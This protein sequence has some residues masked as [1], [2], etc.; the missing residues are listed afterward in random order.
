MVD[1]MCLN[2]YPCPSI[3]SF[4]QGLSCVSNTVAQEHCIK[5]GGHLAHRVLNNVTI[6]KSRDT[7]NKNTKLSLFFD[8]FHHIDDVSSFERY[9][10][11]SNTWG[12][13]LTYA[14]N[15]Y[16]AVNGSGLCGY[17]NIVDHCI[18]SNMVLAVDY[19]GA[20]YLEHEISGIYTINANYY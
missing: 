9:D 13:S 4:E 8:L 12:R 15:T 1:D 11:H 19:F 17:F 5:Y 20:S 6:D 14:R 7:L 16:L 3:K 2:I 10:R 18:D